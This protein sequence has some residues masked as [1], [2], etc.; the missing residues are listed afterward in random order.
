MSFYD[1]V[2]DG[3]DFAASFTRNP[4]MDFPVYA[5]AYR[6]AADRLCEALFDSPQ[7]R[8]YEAYPIVFLY[9]HALE[10]SLKGIIYSCRQISAVRSGD[11]TNE[12]LR[13]RHSL[14]ELS[15]EASNHMA[16]QFQ[17][18][19]SLKEFMERVCSTC[20]EF[21]EIDPS[22][23][24]YRYPID[25]N[26]NPA[27]GRNQI[28]NL[29]AFASHLSGI[30]EELDLVHFGLDVTESRAHDEFELGQQARDLDSV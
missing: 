14:I 13:N 9:R 28:I 7:F 3:A 12:S 24:S 21:H 29:G 20:R 17:S 1:Q 26:G 30:L 16:R 27:T 4:Q 11:S 2:S 19:T 6:L 15:D 25:T 8:C 18:D 5:K 22:S 23:Y 10:L